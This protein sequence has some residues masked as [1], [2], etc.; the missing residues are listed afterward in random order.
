MSVHLVPLLVRRRWVAVAAFLWLAG[1]APARELLTLRGHNDWI[2]CVAFAPD[3]KTL[4]TGSAD[5][6]VKLWDPAQRLEKA[7]IN[8]NSG[9]VRS[10]AFAPDGKSL[11]AGT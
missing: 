1:P 10:V 4:A 8:A 5:R 7:T 2:G 9:E 3:G 6:T 11:A